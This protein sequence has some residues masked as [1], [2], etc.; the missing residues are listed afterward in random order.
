MG[1]S[2]TQEKYIT[3]K[4]STYILA[5]PIDHIFRVITCPP[6]LSQNLRQAQLAQM[7]ECTV[8]ILNLYSWLKPQS[9]HHQQHN[10]FLGR[11]LIIAQRNMGEFYGILVDTPPNLE[12]IPD[13]TIQSVPESFYQIGLPTW[14]SQ[15]AI[16][17]SQDKHKTILM[18]DI[19]QAFAGGR[20]S[21][22]SQKSKI[23]SHKSKSF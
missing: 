15:I 2:L 9:N 3:F 5:L 7:G 20:A 14:V 16:L 18:L 21:T 12:K 6:E 8:M 11:F 4:V 13:S 17:N 10:D 1:K 22:A 19:H 23:K